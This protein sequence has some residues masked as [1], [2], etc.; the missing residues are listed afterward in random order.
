[1]PKMVSLSSWGQMICPL[2]YFVNPLGSN[3]LNPLAKRHMGRETMPPVAEETTPWGIALAVIL[4]ENERRGRKPD[5]W[6]SLGTYLANHP[7]SGMKAESWRDEINKKIRKKPELAPTEK[8]A[9]IFAD[10]LGVDRSELPPSRRR[11]T[12]SSLRAELEVMRAERDAAV[13]AKKLAERVAAADRANREEHPGET[14]RRIAER[15]QPPEQP[16]HGSR[17]RRHG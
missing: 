16:K 8:R 5:T 15:R 2:G 7:Q 3:H 4:A 10:V 17:T 6:R 12:I 9:R 13:E 11:D 1:M 14:A